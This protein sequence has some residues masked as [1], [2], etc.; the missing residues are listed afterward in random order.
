MILSIIRLFS[1]RAKDLDLSTQKILYDQYYTIIYR[2]A[3]RYCAEPNA[4]KDIVQET[5]I[6]AFKYISSYKEQKNGSFEAWLV[7][8]AKNE[9]IKY[10]QKQSKRNEILEEE[11][12]ISKDTLN[13]S[14]EDEV[15]EQITVEEVQSI[16]QTLPELTRAIFLLRFLH[17]FKFKEI[18][19]KLNISENT[20]RQHIFRAKK[21]VQ[22]AIKANWEREQK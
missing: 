11:I 2:T 4:A 21:V 20:A 5:F 7:T 19:D 8:I 17:G 15:I 1:K 12:D 18:G 13:A 14:V 3:Y 22:R 10:I 6:R 9:A 16:I